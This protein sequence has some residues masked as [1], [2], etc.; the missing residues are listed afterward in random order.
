MTSLSVS[1][2]V[3]ALI[4]VVVTINVYPYSRIEVGLLHIM[5]RAGSGFDDGAADIIIR[6][7]Q[8]YSP[9]IVQMLS[10]AKPDSGSEEIAL[11]FVEYVIDQPGVREALK[12]MGNTHTDPAT[13]N[14]SPQY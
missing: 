9:Q 10:G 4:A 5:Y 14:L 7:Q 2:L 6:N 13:R 11:D 12:K 8:R 1:L 3:L